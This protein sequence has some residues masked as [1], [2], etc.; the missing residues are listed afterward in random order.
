MRKMREDNSNCSTALSDLQ[1]GS[2]YSGDLQSPLLHVCA[3]SARTT[4][5]QLTKF[6]ITNPE[7]Q[8]KPTLPFYKHYTPKQVPASRFQLVA[9]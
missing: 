4:N 7:Q 3:G 6:G 2:T 9:S 1:S 8:D 5:S